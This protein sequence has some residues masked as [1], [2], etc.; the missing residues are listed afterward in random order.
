MLAII[1]ATLGM[2]LGGL[3][4]AAFADPETSPAAVAH[5]QNSTAAQ[6]D[7]AAVAAPADPDSDPDTDLVT[8]LASQSWEEIPEEEAGELALMPQIIKVAFGLALVVLLAWGT[9]YL[10]RRTTLGQGMAS[11]NSAVQVIDRNWL[12]PKKAIYLVDI[13]GRTLALGVTEEH[14][15]VLSSWE[16]GE[17]DISRPAP[18]FGTFANQFKGM[19]QR[20]RG[21]SEAVESTQ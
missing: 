13:S 17:I 21:G 18:Q 10:L 9:V 11:N 6:A 16:A 8:D 15:S 20:R 19:L 14:I 1:A 12:G 4:G 2:L 5:E 3:A 7:L